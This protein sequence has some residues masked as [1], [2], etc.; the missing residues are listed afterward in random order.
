MGEPVQAMD[1]DEA[2][3]PAPRSSMRSLSVLE[4]ELKKPVRGPVTY[5]VLGLSVSL[6][7]TAI[8]A[9]LLYWR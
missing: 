7:L 9:T 4:D 6:L 5:V 2:P 3:T 1:A 8:M